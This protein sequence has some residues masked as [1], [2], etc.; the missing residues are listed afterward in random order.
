MAGTGGGGR[1][2]V[3]SAFGVVGADPGFDDW[4]AVPSVFPRLDRRAND[5]P[6]KNQQTFERTSKSFAS[7]SGMPTARM[8]R[9]LQLTRTRHWIDLGSRLCAHERV[10]VRFEFQGCRSSAL[11][12]RGLRGIRATW[13]SISHSRHERARRGDRVEENAIRDFRRSSS[14]AENFGR[15]GRGGLFR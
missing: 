15:R 11:R 2:D 14:F 9:Q 10:I 13:R 6:L 3:G 4:R 12:E 7:Y 5:G 1:K 8:M